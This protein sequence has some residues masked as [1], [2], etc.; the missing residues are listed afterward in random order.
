[1]DNNILNDERF[2]DLEG[3][4]ERRKELCLACTDILEDSFDEQGDFIGTGNRTAFMTYWNEP[5][6]SIYY[7]TGFL[8]SGK[9]TAIVKANKMIEKLQPTADF[10]ISV[11][12]YLNLKEY[13]HL[14]S[15]NAQNIYSRNIESSLEKLLGHDMDF[16]GVN[17][18]FPIGTMTV[19]FLGGELFNHADSIAA[20]MKRLE[21]LEAIYK[22]RGVLTEFNSGCYTVMQIFL[23]AALANH[24]KS[25]EIRERA[26]NCEQRIWVDFLGN[27]HAESRTH[28]GP[29]SRTYMRDIFYPGCPQTLLYTL[30]GSRA[31]RF[32]FGNKEILSGKT[33][34]TTDKN[35]QPL[36]DDNVLGILNVGNIN[37]PF[38]LYH[39]HKDL[40]EWA[41]QKKHP[42]M[43]KATFEYN[44]SRDD[45]PHKGNESLADPKDFSEYRSGTGLISNYMTKNYSLGV[46]SR[47]FHNGAPTDS[48]KVVY[49]RVTPETNAIDAVTV[50]S[51]LIVNKNEIEGTGTIPRYA[52]SFNCSINDEGRKIG[53]HHKQSAMLLYKPKAFRRLKVSDISLSLF[54]T[55]GN[56]TFDELRFGS[57]TIKS[58]HGTSSLLQ[59]VFIR[60]GSVYI[61]IHPLMP[62]DH[63]RKNAIE[64]S[65]FESCTILSFFNY[66][67]EKRDFDRE[68][69]MLTGNGFVIEIADNE[70]YGSF[71][72][73]CDIMG[74]SKIV[75]G[76][77]I[78]FHK[79]N[80]YTRKT[81]YR[82]GPLELACEYSP[83]SE[84]VRY[85]TI[86]GYE[87]LI[88]RLEATGLDLSTV[89][90][91][92]HKNS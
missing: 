63:G 87:P 91:F 1:M 60:D 77:D 61:A 42:Y 32:P 38:T 72:E 76:Y 20:G 49:T 45:N 50:F 40:V 43:L 34:A 23:L 92:M 55:T 29:H 18:N 78:N 75:D 24:T 56:R 73:F 46:A 79:R 3:Q 41:L 58:D 84:G 31:T 4:L 71:D 59:P 8:G 69:F 80:T 89:P 27:Y 39:C 64:L 36:H 85:A 14:L 6:R 74:K 13:G 21:Q 9:G 15:E 66:Q 11:M 12:S 53:L 81:A 17:D 62:V 67:G 70:E 83:V 86:N 48:F 52:R 57:E 37:I 30:L 68:E 47:E 16:V 65:R 28:A 7:S 26:L 2:Y 19:N 44:S 5:Y 51:R 33:P 54:F 90:Y 88:D 35:T 10:W 82:R 25:D 22:R